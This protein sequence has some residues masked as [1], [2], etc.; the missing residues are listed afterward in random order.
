MSVHC[1]DTRSAFER[2]LAGNHFVE[3]RA[4]AEQVGACVQWLPTH[5]L[6]R[7]VLTVPNT[8]PGALGVG[9]AMVSL[10]SETCSP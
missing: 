3:N 9:A 5:L 6:G 10:C 2:A 7:H 8:V 1:F 4:E